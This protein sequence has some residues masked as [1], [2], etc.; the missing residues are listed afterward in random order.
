MHYALMVIADGSKT[1]D[2]M[3]APFYEYEERCDPYTVF[4]EDENGERDPETGLY[5]Y[6]DNPNAQWD[7]YH[8]G[9]R[10]YGL[11]EANVG[12]HGMR[13]EHEFDDVSPFMSDDEYDKA[14]PYEMDGRHFDVAR[15][16]DILNPNDVATHDVLTPDGAWHTRETYN[17]DAP[18]GERFQKIEGWEE[19]F[20][21][22]FLDPYQDCVAIVVDRHV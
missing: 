3:M 15:V 16:R 10:W 18:L 20:K 17:L 8:V 22:K 6:W 5:G 1:L 9:G 11:I 19:D 12:G 13:T 21:A 4:V 7:W 14:M 2:E